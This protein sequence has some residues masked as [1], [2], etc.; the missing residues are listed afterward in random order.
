MVRVKK[1]IKTIPDL[2]YFFLNSFHF[3]PRP[4]HLCGSLFELSQ[5]GKWTSQFHLCSLSVL[6]SALAGG[7]LVWVAKAAVEWGGVFFCFFKPKIFFQ[8]EFIFKSSK[9]TFPLA[10]AF[11]KPTLETVRD[12][13]V[14]LFKSPNYLFSSYIQPRRESQEHL[15]VAAIWQVPAVT[16]WKNKS[17]WPNNTQKLHV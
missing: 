4:L 15:L 3:N 5:P 9:E 1:G 10:Y 7:C 8:G 11:G 6:L 14:S 17:E 16:L 12:L 13:T 2:Y